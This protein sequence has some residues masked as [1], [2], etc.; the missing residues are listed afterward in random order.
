MGTNWREDNSLLFRGSGK[1]NYTNSTSTLL[2]TFSILL[3]RK[4]NICPFSF[5]LLTSEML[6][7]VPSG[8]K[9]TWGEVSSIIHSSM[10]WVWE[11]CWGWELI[12]QTPYDVTFLYSKRTEQLC[13]SFSLPLGHLKSGE[14][15]ISNFLS[16]HIIAILKYLNKI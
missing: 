4:K 12:H 5:N 9:I 6:G 13:A 2:L 8:D 7:R 15:K 14:S 11:E 1:T 10:L 3:K 16:K